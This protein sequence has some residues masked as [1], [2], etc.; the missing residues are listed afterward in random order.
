MRSK[1]LDRLMEQAGSLGAELPDPQY[2]T[3]LRS[4]CCRAGV[5]QEQELVA[6]EVVGANYSL[7]KRQ[8]S[9]RW[10]CNRCG[11]RALVLEQYVL[12]RSRPVHMY[13]AYCTDELYYLGKHHHKLDPTTGHCSCGAPLGLIRG[14]TLSEYYFTHKIYGTRPIPSKNK[15]LYGGRRTAENL[16]EG[17][18]QIQ[19]ILDGLFD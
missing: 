9:G 18:K 19:H 15:F 3:I 4:A 6:V 11:Y 17:A 13:N 10:T 16:S 1:V 5:K 8:W 7:A 14:D 12:N 2:K